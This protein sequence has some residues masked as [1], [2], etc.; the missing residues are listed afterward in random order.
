M[1]D[2]TKPTSP[3]T[4]PET[5][6]DIIPTDNEPT[7]IVP[8]KP[9]P[10][11]IL[12]RRAQAEP[13]KRRLRCLVCNHDRFAEIEITG[14][15]QLPIGWRPPTSLEPLNGKIKSYRCKNCGYVMFFAHEKK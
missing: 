1:T 3:E 15:I 14:Y 7:D 9:D 5:E 6:T 4:A 2:E 8:Q 13:P 10:I 12:V 11:N